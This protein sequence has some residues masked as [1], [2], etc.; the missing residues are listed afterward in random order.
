MQTLGLVM[1]LQNTL[2]VSYKILSLEGTLNKIADVHV[3]D[4]RKHARTW[5]GKGG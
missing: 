4:V 1:I 2:Q 5:G 3:E